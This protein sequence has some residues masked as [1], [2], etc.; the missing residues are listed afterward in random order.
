M[1]L[2][3]VLVVLPPLLVL[4]RTRAY[5]PLRNG[6]AVLT[7]VAAVGWLLDRIGLATPLGTA[8]DALG[9]ASPWIVVARWVGALGT[10]ARHRGMPARSPVQARPAR[11]PGAGERVD[12][13]AGAAP[14]VRLVIA[15]RVGDLTGDRSGSASL[16]LVG[17]R[18]R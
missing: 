18:G 1:Q 16:Q 2:T 9:P 13:P 15:A 7:A 8:A 12:A 4:A 3:V 10:L 6:A 17:A 5:R 11:A 14:H